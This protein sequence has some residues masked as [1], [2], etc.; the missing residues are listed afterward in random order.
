MRCKKLC[1]IAEIKF[2]TVSPSRAKQQNEPSKWLACANFLAD[3]V[4]SLNTSE[5]FITPEREWLLQKDDIVI[6]RIT[7][8]FINYIDSV[9]DNTYCGNNLII[10][11]VKNNMY[12]RYVAMIL[13]SKIKSVSAESSV[14]AVMK[15]ISRSDIEVVEIP[16]LDTQQQILLGDFWFKGIELSKKKTRLVELENIKRTYILKQYIHTLGGYKNGK[17]G[18]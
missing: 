13:N 10:V 6:K 2:C 18:F 17:N 14:G 7:P 3:N 11:T 15:S 9:P 8:T 4:V 12:P 5:S 1:D 16:V